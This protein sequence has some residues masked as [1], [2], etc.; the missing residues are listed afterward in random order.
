MSATAP[1]APITAAGGRSLG[2]S[3][4]PGRRVGAIAPALVLAAATACSPLAFGYYSFSLWAPLGLGAVALTAMLAFGP[5][6]RMTGY[7]RVAAV[8]LTLLVALSFASLLWAQS[9]EAAW[10]SS[11]RVALYTVLFAAGLL[12]VRSL[13]S[14]RLTVL[15]LGLPALCASLVLAFELALGG[16]QSYFLQGRLQWPMGYIN[17]TA[18]L[19]VM[20][21]WPWL[22]FAQTLR[23]SALRAL[24]LAA[25]ALIASAA[26]LTQSRAI[27][28]ATIVAVVLVLA[29]AP[30]RTRRALGVLAVLAAVAST[31][32]WTLRVYSSTGPTQS[33][34]IGAGVLRA[35][36]V[37]I[38]GA[39]AVALALSALGEALRSALTPASRARIGLLLGRGLLV[40]AVAGGVGFGVLERG[41]IAA[42]WHDFTALSPERAAP[43]R[44][45]ALG[46]GFR[47]DL[48]RIAL[49]EFESQ[50]L[51]GVGAGNFVDRYYLLRRQL[52]DVTVPHSLELQEL[53]DLGVGGGIGLALLVGAVL[54]A[55]LERRG[56]TLS[57]ADPGLRVGALGV[58]VAWLAAT[59]VDWLYDIPG[60]AGSAILAAAVLVA[61]AVPERAAAGAAA[62]AAATAR[63]GRS[64]QAALVAA[65]ALLALVAASLGRQYV[66]VLYA[67]AGEALVPRHPLAALSR[68]R[69]SEQL[70]PFSLQTLYDVAS[71]Y[72]RLDDYRAARA[73]LVR[74]E[75]LEPDNY[76]PP[77]LLGDIA[78]RAG[79]QRAALAD[80][81]RALALDP[82]EPTLHEAVAQAKA[83]LSASAR[84]AKA[85]GR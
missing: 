28:L 68:L 75:Q 83:A 85:V 40:L 58:F 79:R 13:A 42:Q 5:P 56:R 66:A 6:P 33:L 47:Y 31:A 29:C 70:D 3:G 24:S 43:D 60:L 25:A 1:I 21:I 20:G 38:L 30:G 61:P 16:G 35:A 74:A 14:A 7:G 59:S 84:R 52:E 19:L 82:L 10:T 65:V 22:G 64:G 39:A 44:F 17:G 2:E 27:L 23:H 73:A 55:A 26:L 81:R 18:G 11:N 36:G 76:V 67:D 69:S 34:A 15:V 48:W 63:R 12:A 62:G 49:D 46:G 54:A 72:A 77:A 8:G 37:A 78:T 41:R 80:Y 50:P 53:A 9:R 32:T 4:L 45:L 51:G 71:A 57:D